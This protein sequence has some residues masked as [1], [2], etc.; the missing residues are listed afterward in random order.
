LKINQFI[1]KKVLPMV[2]FEVGTID[3]VVAG[4]I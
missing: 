3:V 1:N 4:I 2:V